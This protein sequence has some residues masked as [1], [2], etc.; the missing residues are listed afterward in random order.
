MAWLMEMKLKSRRV[1]SVSK[2]AIQHSK[3]FFSDSYVHRGNP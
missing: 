2:N 1:T 3:V